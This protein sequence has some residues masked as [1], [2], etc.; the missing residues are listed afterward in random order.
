MPVRRTVPP[1]MLIV[2]PPYGERLGEE[3]EW[4]G[5][6]AK[7]GDVAAAHWRGWRVLVFTG[8]DWLARKVGL[9]LRRR[10]PFFNGKI[11]CHLWEFET[12]AP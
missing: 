1:G 6:Y 12:T 10:T 2:N 5:L 7:L 4:A 3:R 9:P 11:P 8:N